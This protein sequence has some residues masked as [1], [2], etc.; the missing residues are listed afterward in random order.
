MYISCILKL[1]CFHVLILQLIRVL[2]NTRSASIPST[3][4]P[5]PDLV[6]SSAPAS[7]PSDDSSPVSELQ[8]LRRI[9]GFDI[10]SDELGHPYVPFHLDIFR[11]IRHAM[12]DLTGSTFGFRVH[13]GE[14]VPIPA[15]ELSIA[16]EDARQRHV[17]I[18]KI[19]LQGIL[20]TKFREGTI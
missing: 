18:V 9:V 19:C 6:T 20:E 1:L 13:C 8:Y 12:E 17:D 14:I 10:M 5:A 3:Q 11:A 15:S 4:P 16:M 2:K 7:T